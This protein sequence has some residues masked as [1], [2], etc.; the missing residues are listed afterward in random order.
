MK[1]RIILYISALL[2]FGLYRSYIPAPKYD[3]IEIVSDD[4]FRLN[5]KEHST[6]TIFEVI[7]D[8]RK[9]LNPERRN[10][11]AIRLI[12]DDNVSMGYVQDVKVAMRKNGLLRIVYPVKPF[13][14]FWN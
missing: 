2:I 4:I 10:S 12:I 7:S 6:D 9:S 5:N 14:Q 11:I 8:F 13:W 3:T 1:S